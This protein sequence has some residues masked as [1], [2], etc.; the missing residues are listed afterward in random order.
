MD[1]YGPSDGVRGREERDSDREG[2][3]GGHLFLYKVNWRHPPGR[4][5]HHYGTSYFI[6]TMANLFTKHAPY[7]IHKSLGLLVLLHYLY[8]MI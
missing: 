4:N 6:L 5:L 2:T 1:T 8:R 3:H 7:N